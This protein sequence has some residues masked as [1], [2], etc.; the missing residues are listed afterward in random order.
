MKRIVSYMVVFWL[1]LLAGCSTGTED[2]TNKT[3]GYSVY[4]RSIDNGG[5]VKIDYRP[6]VVTQS[7]L[8]DFL[9]Q[10][11]CESPLDAEGVSVVPKELEMKGWE[12]DGRI[13]ICDFN[14]AYSRMEDATELLFRAALVKTMV[15]V[16]GVEAVQLRVEGN[17]L[18]DRAGNII[19]QQNA[20]DYV[21]VLGQGLNSLNKTKITLYFSN[22]TGDKLIPVT[23]EYAYENA[24]Q[25]EKE[26]IKYLIEG[27]RE[28]EAGCYPVLP[29]K[30]KLLSTTTKDGI[31][32]VNFD[33]S[34]I[35]D[36]LDVNAN[37]PIYALVNSLTEL[38]GIK[39]VKIQIDGASN[40]SFKNTFSLEE[41]YERNY[42]LVEV[43]ISQ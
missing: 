35:N 16:D 40:L 4:Y 18:A 21:D 17:Q 8:I 20:E 13:M 33:V 19:P 36:A 9:W 38:S 14:S 6:Q 11:M 31:C 23:R 43:D 25:F 30:V 28:E 15:G 39:S 42:N 26:V 22:E 10:K 32:Y 3:G 41:T 12:M 2:D 34:F 29:S 1:L 24:P 27:P 37:I 5:L 7:G